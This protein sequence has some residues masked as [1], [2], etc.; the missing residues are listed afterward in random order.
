M[1]IR[2][3]CDV[4][5]VKFIMNINILQYNLIFKSQRTKFNFD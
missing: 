1:E 4:R 3:E 5:T 2:N